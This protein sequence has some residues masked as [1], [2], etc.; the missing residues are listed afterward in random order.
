MFLNS[1][2]SLCEAY[3][4]LYTWSMVLYIRASFTTLYPNSQ[5]LWEPGHSS[6]AVCRQHDADH[7]V[8]T[9]PQDRLGSYCGGD[10][11]VLAFYNKLFDPKSKHLV[12]AIAPLSIGV[13]RMVAF[14][15]NKYFDGLHCLLRPRRIRQRRLLVVHKGN[16]AL[17]NFLKTF[18]CKNSR[19]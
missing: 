12:C 9:S 19:S 13:L 18:Q 11:V 14:L 8:Q 6:K 16:G 2:L 1:N 5:A 7:Q 15:Q 10:P 17:E 3:M 4:Q